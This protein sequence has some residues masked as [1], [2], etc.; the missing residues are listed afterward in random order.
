MNTFSKGCIPDNFE[1]HSSPKLSFINIG[2]LGSSFVECKSFLKS[3]SPD[4]L[5]LYETN[6]NNSI[7]FGNFSVKGYFPVIGKGSTT[8]MHGLAVYVMEGLPFYRDLS[9]ENPAYSYLCFR[10]VLLH[11]VSYFFFLYRSPSLCL[12][13]AFGS[14]SSNIDE[15]LSINPSANVLAFGDFNNHHR[16]W[17]IYSIGIVR[18]GEFCYNF[19]IS[20]HLTEM[21]NFHTQIPDCD[22]QSLALLYLFIFSDASNCSAM[23]FPS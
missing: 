22:S 21:S 17:L 15:V 12:F 10:L 13:K 1:S 14:I 4:I 6:L 8:H 9:L 19:S 20:N 16:N 7:D 5:A 23:G 18:P 2:G 11:S 3:N